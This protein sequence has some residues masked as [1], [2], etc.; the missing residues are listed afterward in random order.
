MW[1]RG[2]VHIEFSR[3][4]LRER[5]HLEELGVE[6]RIV[7]KCIVKNRMRGRVLE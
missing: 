1:G 4:D 2:E 5:G 6:G 3:G 7:L